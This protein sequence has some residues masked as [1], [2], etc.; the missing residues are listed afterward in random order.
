MR[1]TSR[2][3]TNDDISIASTARLTSSGKRSSL[4]HIRSSS[5]DVVTTSIEGP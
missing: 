1:Y 5:S 3:T 2:T 4:K